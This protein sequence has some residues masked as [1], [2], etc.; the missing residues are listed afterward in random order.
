VHDEGGPRAETAV[1]LAQESLARSG[2]LH[3]RA[4]GASML[5]ALRPGDRLEFVAC[6]AADIPVGAIALCRRGDRLFVHRVIGHGEGLL[7][8]QGDALAQPDPP[9]AHEQVLGRL[10]SFERRAGRHHRGEAF[11]QPRLRGLLLRRSA[12]LTRMFLR[13]HALTRRSAA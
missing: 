1:A 5:P 8:T 6:S 11:R 2:R 12:W 4:N 10:E 7:H 13:W 9:F 3:L